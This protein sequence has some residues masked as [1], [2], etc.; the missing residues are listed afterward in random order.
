VAAQYVQDIAQQ[1]A[2]LHRAGQIHRDVRPT[3]IVI[4]ASRAELETPFDFSDDIADYEGI[5]E[6][7]AAEFA[8]FLAPKQALN[9]GSADERSDIYSLGCVL[10]FMLARRPPFGTGTIAER[11]LKQQIATP[12][13]LGNLRSDVPQPLT[14][15]CEKMLAKKPAER[16]QSASEVAAAFHNMTF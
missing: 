10:F 14:E 12:E 11:L 5:T 16:Y 7:S 1:L 9:C 6:E 8:D 13:A 2:Q 4:R 15:I 3:R